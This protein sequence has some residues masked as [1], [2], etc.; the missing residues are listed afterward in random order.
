MMKNVERKQNMVEKTDIVSL[1]K[2]SLDFGVGFI[3]H[4]V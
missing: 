3:F 2:T 4:G 1:S